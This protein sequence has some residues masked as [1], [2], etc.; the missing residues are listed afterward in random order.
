MEDEEF[1]INNNNLLDDEDDNINLED[2]LF[3]EE[4]LKPSNIL[5]DVEEEDE[6][7]VQDISIK[8][9]MSKIITNPEIKLIKYN[10]REVAEEDLFTTPKLIY[11][12]KELDNSDDN[13]EEDNYLFKPID[14]VYEDRL[15]VFNKRREQGIVMTSTKRDDK[16]KNEE[17]RPKGFL[18]TLRD[19]IRLKVLNK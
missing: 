17:I 4:F 10:R 16:K 6:Y 12:D 5:M 3:E 1:L 13:E 2:S 14:L 11:D 15:E 9:E 18:V 19:E 7:N 8:K